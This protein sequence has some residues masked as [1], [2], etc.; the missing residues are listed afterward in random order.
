[1]CKS[2]PGFEGA[3]S[4]VTLEMA[5]S[6]CST[7]ANWLVEVRSWRFSLLSRCSRAASCELLV[8]AVA[9]SR[10]SRIMSETE[11]L[12]NRPREVR[13]PGPARLVGPQDVGKRGLGSGEPQE[14]GLPST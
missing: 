13:G 1:M 9:V 3:P 11:Q 6:L 8:L 12:W 7:L 10:T 5:A 14:D 4:S 2:R